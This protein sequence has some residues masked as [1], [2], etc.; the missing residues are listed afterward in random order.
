MADEEQ[1]L[2]AYVLVE[3]AGR[4]ADSV[5]HRARQRDRGG[6][7]VA[8]KR[9]RVGA[10]P[11]AL[12]RLRGEAEVLARLAHPAIVPLLD[13][14]HD[15]DAGGV[16]LVLP[17]A[18]G[19]SLEDVLRRDG[20]LPWPRVADVGARLASALATAH[21]AGVLHR[22]VKPANVLLGAE[23]EP[24]LADFGIARLRAASDVDVVGTAEYL[25]PAVAVDG[26]PPSPRSDGYALGIVL[27]RALAGQLPVAG[28]SPEATVAAA[29]RG[30]HAPLADLAPD[31]PPVL[32]D[33]IERAMARD[34]EARFASLQQLQVVLEALVTEHEADQ[35]DRLGQQLA[36]P[37]SGRR[38][39][40]QPPPRRSR[41]RHRPAGTAVPACSGPGHP[42]G[43]RRARPPAG[44]GGPSRPW[45]RRC[46]CP[47]WC[48]PGCC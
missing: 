37:G 26:Q 42:P 43:P 20:A 32:V 31:A 16:A 17:W 21:A 22:D 35:W 7:I 4:G 6:R 15:P 11:D 45:S 29:A 13:V 10:T 23:D 47:C 39:G 33:A 1:V 28:G 19:G 46:S 41:T 5:V 36:P 24:R 18:P 34:P 44:R 40:P 2:G 3:V 38:P 30:V 25:D 12:D 9:L 14:L 27:Y 8:V 48:W